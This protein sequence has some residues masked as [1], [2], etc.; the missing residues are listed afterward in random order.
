MLLGLMNLVNAY[1][2]VCAYRFLA[3]YTTAKHLHLTPNV[4]AEFTPVWFNFSASFSAILQQSLL[5]ILL[6][7]YSNYAGIH[8]TVYGMYCGVLKIDVFGFE[9]G[10]AVGDINILLENCCGHV[11][12][13]MLVSM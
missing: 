7:N 8:A 12:D 6:H 5:L 2:F 9:L 3:L 10:R 11:D 13:W 1:C 4:A